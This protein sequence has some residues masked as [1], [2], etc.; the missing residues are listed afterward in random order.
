M[1][2]ID[3]KLSHSGTHLE[4]TIIFLSKIRCTFN[5]EGV[6]IVQ[7][8]MCYCYKNFQ[9]G[10]TYEQQRTCPNNCGRTANLR[11]FSRQISSCFFLSCSDSLLGYPIGDFQALQLIGFLW[12]LVPW[13]NHL[14]PVCWPTFWKVWHDSGFVSL[15]YWRTN[16]QYFF[17]YVLHIFWCL[18]IR[19]QSQ[20][21]V[22]STFFSF[23]LFSCLK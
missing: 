4:T 1:F 23:V 15:T 22:S 8:K 16:F 13:I 19:I 20:N 9:T 21:W 11:T 14:H 7:L 12:C 17:Y 10:I 2:V 3:G 18:T 5:S 6:F